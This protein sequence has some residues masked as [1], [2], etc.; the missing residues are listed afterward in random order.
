MRPSKLEEFKVGV[1]GDSKLDKKVQNSPRARGNGSVQA[2][3]RGYINVNLDASQKAQF[4]DWMRTDYPWDTMAAVVASGAHIAV[5]LNQDG[6]GFLASVTQRNPGHI[7]AG[8]AVTARAGEA[9]KAMFRALFL[10]AVLGV[11]A[12]W[13]AG[14]PPADPD[15]W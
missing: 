12:D 2:E 10:V 1:A 15:R 9:G 7:N 6:G 3:W 8:L 13:A 14:K 4:E 5:K 11:D